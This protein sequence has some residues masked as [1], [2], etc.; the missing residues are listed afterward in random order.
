MEG[1]ILTQVNTT[2]DKLSNMFS[3]LKIAPN[4]NASFNIPIYAYLIVF[5]LLAFGVYGI[6]KGGKHAR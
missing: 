5:A 1:N 2:I 6:W 4:V 3:N